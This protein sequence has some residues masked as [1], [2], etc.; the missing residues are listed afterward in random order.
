MS[1]T[2]TR[3]APFPR[4]RS[5]GNPPRVASISSQT[6]LRILALACAIFVRGPVIG[7]VQ[8]PADRGIGRRLPQHGDNWPSTSMSDIEVAPIAIAIAVDA[9]VTPRLTCGDVPLCVRAASSAG[10]QART[11]R[12]ACAAASRR[13][14]RPGRSR[15]Q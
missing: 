6:C 11:G 12:R 15:R 2:A 7:Q 9:S 4:A 5:Q 14:G 8:G 1:M 3:P 13:H 10:G